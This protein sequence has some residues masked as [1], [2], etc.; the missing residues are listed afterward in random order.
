MAEVVGGRYSLLDGA[1]VAT[2][3]VDD[4]TWHPT[5][6]EVWN[7]AGMLVWFRMALGTGQNLTQAVP[8]GG[9]QS[10]AIPAAIRN[11]LTFDPSIDPEFSTNPEWSFQL[12]A[13][14]P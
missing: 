8:P 7:G 4:G 3:Y 10:W 1:V 5:R 12:R 2:T 11:K 14:R 13:G 6:V 9:L